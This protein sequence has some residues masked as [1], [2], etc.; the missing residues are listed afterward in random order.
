MLPQ[1]PTEGVRGERALPSAGLGRI[2]PHSQLFF[3]WSFLFHRT[4]VTSISGH[5]TDETGVRT[6]Q[7]FLS[8]REVLQRE[9]QEWA[10]EEHKRGGPGEPCTP[11][12]RGD[13]EAWAGRLP[14]FHRWPVSC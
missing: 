6:P 14:S 13:L 5:S 3:L 7:K 8:S 2:R 12:F 11:H 10:S 9:Q 1:I 4:R